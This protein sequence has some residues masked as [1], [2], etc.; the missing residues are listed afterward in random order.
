MALAPGMHLGPYE[1][2]T[3]LG[4]GGMGEVY[5]AR[6]TRLDRT[7]AVK[8][9]PAHFSKDP[10]RKQRF[11]REAKTISALNH[12]NICV[13]YDVG[14]QDGIDFLVMECVEG[15][16]LA[17]R[18]EKGPL[19][20]EQVLKIGC[21][22]ADALDR[23]HH[24]GVIHRD[25]TPANIMLTKSGSKLLDFG[26]AKP[27][28]PAASGP[29]L[30]A[31][32]HRMPV[33]QEGTIVGTFPY[34]SL[35]QMEGSE[36]DGRTDIFSLGAVLYEMLTGRRAFE[37]KSQWSA[38]SAILEREPADIRAIKPTT[39][40]ALDRLVKDCLVKD[41]EERLQSAHD[42]KLQLRWISEAGS[43]AAASASTP[44]GLKFPRAAGWM[45]AAIGL[46]VAM[47]LAAG[48]Y[49]RAPNV[50]GTVRSSLL[51]PRGSSFKPYNLAVSPDGMRL[52]FVA[53]GLDGKNT[54]WSRA[55]STASAQPLE[56]T[57]GGMFPFWSPDSG[58]LGFFAQGKLKVIDIRHL[59]HLS[60]SNKRGTSPRSGPDVEVQWSPHSRCCDALSRQ[61]LW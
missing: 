28:V 58:S 31:A 38:A 61:D 6:D 16:S 7:V 43:Q 18:L 46:S 17:L 53:T 4:A 36:L 14:Y 55:L 11:D 9:L 21:E 12:P 41:R 5:R 48:Y 10:V 56:G 29:T 30:T 60:R 50:V 45:F 57:E 25:L 40:A 34:M 35:E 24:S 52:V 42:V 2:I 37:G 26:L 59:Q 51:P 33:T 1:I 54:L 47:V 13:L 22:I 32:A 20:I 19:P 8:I 44:T 39:P 49:F 23:A 27:A 3:P 15:E